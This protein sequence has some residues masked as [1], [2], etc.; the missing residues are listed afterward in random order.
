[1][2]A[3]FYFIIFGNNVNDQ[4]PKKYQTGDHAKRADAERWEFFDQKSIY[5]YQ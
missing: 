2:W 4:M 3:R 5:R 1:M